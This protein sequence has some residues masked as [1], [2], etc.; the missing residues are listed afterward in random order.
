[1]DVRGM[2]SGEVEAE[3]VGLAGQLAAGQCRFLVLL[4]EFDTRQAWAGPGLRSCAHWLSWRIGMDR[5]TA[6][7][8]VRVA[9]ALTGLP[10]LT[11]AFAAG[12]VS[13][14]KVRAI[15]RIA[16]PATEAELLELALAGTAAHV[17]RV[18]ALARAANTDPAAV[19]ATRAVRWSWDEDGCL[20]LR[21]RLTP[22]AGAAVLATLQAFLDPGP[23]VGPVADTGPEA[24]PDTES[25]PRSGERPHIGAEPEPE[26][27]AEPA[28]GPGWQAAQH[29]RAAAGAETAPGATVDRAAARRADALTAMAELA[30]AALRQGTASSPV[31]PEVLVHLRADGTAEIDNGPALPPPTAHRMVCTARAAALLT[32]RHGNPLNLGRSRRLVSRR[33]LRALRARDGGCCRYPGCTNRIVDAHHLLS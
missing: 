26:G 32:D 11:A 28:P 33:Q 20:L 1:M 13:Y 27:G 12:R 10:Q 5:R 23:D 18:V 24:A 22:E 15:T 21:A 9:H 16:T 2:G 17:E 6:Q 29:D 3:L 14:S 30:H 19:A 8:Q 4:A 31:V 25:H 7:D